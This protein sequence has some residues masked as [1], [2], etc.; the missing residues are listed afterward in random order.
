MRQTR[1]ASPRQGDVAVSGRSLLVEVAARTAISTATMPFMYDDAR[2]S[3]DF[4][5]W[6]MEQELPHGCAS[7]S[8]CESVC[9]SNCVPNRTLQVEEMI[10]KL[11]TTAQV[12]TLAAP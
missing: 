7:G 12:R 1:S 11:N 10:S 9:A 4:W 3:W 2:F 5:E 8:F 6:S